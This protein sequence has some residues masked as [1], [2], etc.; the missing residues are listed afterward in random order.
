GSSSSC[1]FGVKSVAIALYTSEFPDGKFV[2]IN[3]SCELF[4]RSKPVF[5]M[6]HGFIANSSSHHF[7]ELAS[8]LIKRGYTVFSLDW[9]DASCYNDPGS[10]SLLEPIYY[11]FAIRNAHKISDYLTRYI[12][13]VI[14]ICH[15]SLKNMIFMGHSLGAHIAGFAGK[16]FQKLR[17][18]IFPLL[19]G[20]DPAAPILFALKSCENRF[21]KSDA[22]RTI[23]IHVSILGIQ[24]SLGHL[25]LW[26]NNGINQPACGDKITGVTNTSCTHNI[27]LLYLRSTLLDDCVFD[28]V[29]ISPRKIP[30]PNL[31]PGCSSNKTNC[32]VVDNRLFEP[33]YS[34]EGNYCVSVSSQSPF[35]TKKNDSCKK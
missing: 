27:G 22:E 7:S 35:C 1:V 8:V 12:K 20:S 29:P 14:D 19:F 15:V 6:V 25:D 16:S 32:V 2:K 17:Y 10:K 3:E 24:K 23:V 34:L 30:I 28:S 13:E 21:C 26:P 18:G 5:F 11:L 31:V 4:D 9:A 33:S